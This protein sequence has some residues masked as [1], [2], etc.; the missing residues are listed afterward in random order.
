[1]EEN[2]AID[3]QLFAAIEILQ[4]NLKYCFNFTNALFRFLVSQSN[5][6]SA[7]EESTSK[8]LV[9]ETK[10][11]EVKLRCGSSSDHWNSKFSQTVIREIRE[12]MAQWRSARVERDVMCSIP[13]SGNIALSLRSCPWDHTKI[14]CIKPPIQFGASHLWSG[15]NYVRLKAISRWYIGNFLLENKP[16]GM[17]NAEKPRY[18]FF[19][20]FKNIFSFVLFSK[21]FFFIIRI[22]KGRQS[23]FRTSWN[24]NKVRNSYSYLAKPYSNHSWSSIASRNFRRCVSHKPG[25]LGHAQNAKISFLRYG[26]QL[27]KYI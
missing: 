17:R 24:W 18:I 11:L 3:F 23:F 4:T 16:H 25:P 22:C 8:R 10:T 27:S 2:S 7:T 13:T 19:A 20:D 14:G 21:S 6:L 9:S 15:A 12:A 26:C 5:V 1:M